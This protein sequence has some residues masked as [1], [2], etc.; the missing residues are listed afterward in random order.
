MLY[1]SVMYKPEILSDSSHKR[2]PLFRVST[3][4]VIREFFK[5][6]YIINPDKSERIP[7]SHITPSYE[8][9]PPLS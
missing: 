1:D 7:G 2:A 6:C 3:D 4:S 5:P 8:I 9:T